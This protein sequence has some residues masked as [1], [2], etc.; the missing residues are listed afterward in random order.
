MP[1]ASA[2]PVFSGKGVPVA[3]YSARPTA[4][5]YGA[6][7]APSTQMVVRPLSPALNSTGVIMSPRSPRQMLVPSVRLSKHFSESRGRLCLVLMCLDMVPFLTFKM[8][9]ISALCILFAFPHRLVSCC[10]NLRL[11]SCLI[12]FLRCINRRASGRRCRS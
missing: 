10:F 7:I 6:S 1:G 2:V 11:R 9:L 12:S 3:S 8:Q 4:V 5:P